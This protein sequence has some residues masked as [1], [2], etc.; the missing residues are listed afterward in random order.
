MFENWGWTELLGF[1][2]LW[3]KK[4]LASPCFPVVVWY[5]MHWG[6]GWKLSRRQQRKTRPSWWGLHLSFTDTNLREV[7]HVSSC[8]HAYCLSPILS[9]RFNRSSRKDRY[10]KS[11]LLYW[12]ETSVKALQRLLSLN[13]SK[14]EYV[15]KNSRYFGSIFRP[16]CSG[17]IELKYGQSTKLAITA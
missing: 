1:D 16:R 13:L 10:E 6:T 4:L 3:Y 5:G 11:T 9:N 12:A 15:C 2:M 7:A 8:H 14:V 17:A